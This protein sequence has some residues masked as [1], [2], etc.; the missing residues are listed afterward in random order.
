MDKF[1]IKVDKDIMYEGLKKGVEDAEK[2][3]NLINEHASKLEDI[4]NI[5]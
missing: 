3:K 1:N 4:K 5:G 2:F